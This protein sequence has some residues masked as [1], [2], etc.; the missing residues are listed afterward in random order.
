MNNLTISSDTKGVSLALGDLCNIFSQIEALSIACHEYE[1]RHHYSEYKERHIE[2][3]LTQG[4]VAAC[5]DSYFNGYFRISNL[6]NGLHRE[7]EYRQFGTENGQASI[8]QIRIYNQVL[9]NR[10]IQP[11]SYSR[12]GVEYFTYKNPIKVKL[13]TKGT[14]KALAVAVIIC[15]GE[16][17]LKSGKAKM[18]GLISAVERLAELS[19]KLEQN[20]SSPST[21]DL[22]E[23]PFPSPIKD[24]VESLPYDDY[25]LLKED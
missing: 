2:L 7:Y 21:E 3:P 4:L 23:Y 8:A 17:D 9:I 12:S 22:S 11:K 6:Y 18:P 14:I 13:T 5:L 15:G 20:E 24:Y 1:T 25:D 19:I 10:T 16:I